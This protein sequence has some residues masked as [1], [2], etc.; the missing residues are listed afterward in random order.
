M[1][2]E[3]V[4]RHTGDESWCTAAVVLLDMKGR[5]PLQREVNKGLVRDN[6]EIINSFAQPIPIFTWY[7]S[8]LYSKE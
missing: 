3:V 4:G 2:C 5:G 1:N 8:M 7:T 6:K